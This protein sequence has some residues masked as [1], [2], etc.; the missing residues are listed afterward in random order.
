M[1]KLFR[2]C[3]ENI[4]VPVLALFFTDCMIEHKLSDPQAIMLEIM[5]YTIMLGIM[6]VTIYS[7]RK[8]F[9]NK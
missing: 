2:I 3:W 4:I 7:L 5:I 9:L 6:Y 1:K 8:D